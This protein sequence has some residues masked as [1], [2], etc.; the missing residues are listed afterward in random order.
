MGI[1]KEQSAKG[2]A[3]LEQVSGQQSVK[4]KMEEEV[5]ILQSEN[6][7]LK[8]KMSQRQCYR[9]GREKCPQGCKC[10]ANGQKC[11]KCKKMNHFAKVCRSSSKGKKKSSFGQLS[12][13]DESDSEESSGRIVVGKLDS[14]T[15]GAKI[16]VQ[17]PLNTH[18]A[19]Y[20]MLATDTGLSKTLPDSSDWSKVKGGCKFVKTSKHFRPY[21]TKY[22][23][24]IKGKARVTL[25]AERGAKIDTW[26]YVV[27]DKR[28]QSLLG[29]SDAVRLGIVKL[30]LK[31][32]TEE[33][34]GRVSHI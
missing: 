34:I 26:V 7:Q 5:R 18:H 29:E 32:S 2:A 4:V 12:S 11:S 17:G 10:P 22:H 3:F 15:I 24:L 30:D 14:Q 6:K 31:G 20:L 27:N 9:C 23:L 21:G 25:T 33:V 1:V 16:T 8:S 19:V 13:A 28:E